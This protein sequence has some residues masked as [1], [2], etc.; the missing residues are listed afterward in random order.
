GLP[1]CDLNLSDMS[2]LGFRRVSVGSALSR[3]ALGAFLG[4]AEEMQTR[5]TFTFTGQATSSRE[6]NAIF[7]T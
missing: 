7:A 2:A 6:I 1:G 4:A 5:G 3:A